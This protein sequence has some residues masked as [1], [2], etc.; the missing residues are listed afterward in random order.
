V[1]NPRRPERARR[2]LGGAVADLDSLPNHVDTRVVPEIHPAEDIRTDESLRST[3]RPL[4]VGMVQIAQVNWTHRK[5][6]QYYVDDGIIKPKSTN[7]A[8]NSSSFVYLPY[9]VGMLQAYVQRNAPHPERYRWLLPICR[10]LPIPELVAAMAE[11]DVVGFSTYVWNIRQNLAAA[12]TLKRERPDRLIVFGGPEVP[13]SA[14]AF[15]RQN[16][17]IDV[18]CHGEGERVFLDILEHADDRDWSG[19]PSVSYIGRD[20][21]FINTKPQGRTANISQFPSPYLNGVFDELIRANPKQGWLAMWETNRGCP[22]SCT[23]CDWGSAVASKV[24][25]FDLERLQ[26]EMDWFAQRGMRFLFICDA[27]FGI[28][29]RDV[30]IARYLVNTYERHGSFVN[31]SIQNAKNQ[32]ERTYAI[33]R[34]LSQS[35]VATF[36]ATIALQGVAEQTLKAIKRDN[37]SLSAFNELQRRFKRDGLETYTDV[38]VGLPGETYESFADG[39]ELVIKNGQHNRMTSYNC[40]VLINAEMGNP[41]YQRRYGIEKVPMRIVY[42]HDD[43]AVS[44]SEDVHEFI[45]TIAAT[46]T[47]SRADWRRVRCLAWMTELLHFNRLLQIV[48]TVLV[49]HYGLGYRGLVEAF[50]DPDVERYPILASVARIFDEQAHRIQNAEPEFIASRE[51]LGIWWPVDQYA[52]VRLVVS[53]ELT[54]FYAEAHRLLAQ[55]LQRRCPDA[56][57]GPLHDAIALNRAAFRIPNCFE[58]EQITLDSDVLGFYRGVLD[59]TDVPLRRRPHSYHINRTGTVWLSWE[60][61]AKDVVLQVYQRGQYLYPIKPLAELPDVMA[62]EDGRGS[63]LRAPC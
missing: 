21:A 12:A 24:Y 9:S 55:L 14:E 58:D 59:G 23:F 35:K 26:A 27:N 15:L 13:A 56:D 43:I 39:L 28:L 46:N 38:I 5:K 17:F 7:W 50:L 57:M 29:P 25:R 53:G 47:L 31:I 42:Q 44:E 61:W 41:D 30:E 6:E 18:A 34:I 63:T 51:L 37:I 11:A 48:F 16:P 62:M 36:G 32:V 33:Q 22:F 20:G 52:V 45:D 1:E 2:A 54:A 4:T 49:E 3:R 60:A 40:S 19:V 10:R 8:G